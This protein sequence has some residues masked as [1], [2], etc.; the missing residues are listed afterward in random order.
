MNEQSYKKC[1]IVQYN[2]LLNQDRA[3]VDDMARYKKIISEFSVINAT[4][5]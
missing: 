4:N 5:V 1:Y 3:E 2:E